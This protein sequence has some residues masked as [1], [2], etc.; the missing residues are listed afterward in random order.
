MSWK[1]V[2]RQDLRSR[3]LS[4][5]FFPKDLSHIALIIYNTFMQTFH[6]ALPKM[7]RHSSLFETNSQA[8]GCAQQ[9]TGHARAKVYLPAKQKQHAGQAVAIRIS[10]PSSQRSGLPNKILELAASR[11][12]L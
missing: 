7:P 5:L 6:G 9:A 11:V 10:G 4:S 2:S 8:T 12:A 1:S 3:R